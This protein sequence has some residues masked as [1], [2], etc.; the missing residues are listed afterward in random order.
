M[1]F[2]DT[3]PA[4]EDAHFEQVK[5][6]PQK[7]FY[8]ILMLA[9]PKMLELIAFSSSRLLMIPFLSTPVLIYTYMPLFLS[10]C[11]TKIKIKM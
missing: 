2:D 4:K 10:F 9:Y 11:L 3:N 5:T 1:R 6:L 7:G 8:R